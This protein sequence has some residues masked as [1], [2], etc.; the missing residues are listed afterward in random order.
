[1]VLLAAGTT[2]IVPLDLKGQMGDIVLTK[3]DAQ[4]SGACARVVMEFVI[5]N[6][7]SAPGC[8]MPFETAPGSPDA[9]IIGRIRRLG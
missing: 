2:E 4:P 6:R 8:A 7:K 3:R 9:A 1:L 5:G